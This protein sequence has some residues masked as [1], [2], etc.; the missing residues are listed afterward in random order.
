MTGTKLANWLER[1]ALRYGIIGIILFNAV[2]LGLET[3]PTVM[4]NAGPL[5]RA[6]DIACLA[7]F[8]AELAAKIIAYRARF[9]TSGW[10]LFDFVI[11]GVSLTPGSQTL[12]VL[13]ALRILRVLRVISVAPRL[14]RF[15]PW[16]Q[17]LEH[18]LPITGIHS[19][20][21]GP[22]FR[23]DYPWHPTFQKL[24]PLLPKSLLPFRQ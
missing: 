10:N 20:F 18:R 9:F 12:S 7:I 5:I 13:R 15:S 17:N 3:S 1:P 23:G 19:S 4:D 14:R 11:V 22:Q 21:S 8:V 16:F 2:L 6:L 24:L